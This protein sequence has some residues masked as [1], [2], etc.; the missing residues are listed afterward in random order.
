MDLDVHISGAPAES[1]GVAFSAQP[2]ALAVVNACGDFDFKRPLL[3]HTAGATALFAGMLDELAGAAARRARSGP[4]ELAEH[5]A[6]DLTHAPGPAAGRTGLDRR[7]RFRP[8]SAAT[9][10]RDRDTER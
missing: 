8:I 1:A 10:A 2:D 6:R 7:I 9:P 3:D 5:A 4:D